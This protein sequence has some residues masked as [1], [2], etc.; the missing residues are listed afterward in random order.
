MYEQKMDIECE[1]GWN[2]AVAKWLK[3]GIEF[4]CDWEKMVKKYIEREKNNGKKKIM[5]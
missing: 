1:L 5:E 3:R 2:R 4:V